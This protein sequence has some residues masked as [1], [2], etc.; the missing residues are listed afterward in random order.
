MGIKA[1]VIVAVCGAVLSGCG[2]SRQEMLAAASD[3][4]GAYGYRPGSPEYSQCMMA[5][6]GQYMQME[7]QRRQNVQQGLA[8]MQ[9]SMNPPTTTCRTGRDAF[10][11][12]I[13]Q[14]Q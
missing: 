2:P 13:T 10:G 9:R 6:D 11:Q 5:K 7:Q 3:D 14:C 12:I 4:C 8:N 1:L